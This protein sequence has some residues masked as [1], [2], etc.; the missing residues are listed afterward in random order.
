MKNIPLP[1]TRR[2]FEAARDENGVPHVQAATWLDALFGL[3]YM[4][5][6][7]R[8]TQL[9][10]SR[11][12]ASGRGAEEISDT[13]EL[14]ETDRFFRRIGLNLDLETEIRILDDRT[15]TQLTAYCEGVNDGL[16]GAGRSLPM[17]AAGFQPQPWNQQSVLLIG[18][19][20]SF[21]GLAV[22]QMQN[23]RLLIELIHA[24]VDDEALRDLFA[25][26]L[27][28]VDFAMIRQIKMANQL[29]DEA[30]ELITDLPRL[31]GSNAWAVSP[32]R[33]ATGY[34]LL[35]ADPHLEINRLPAIWY[36]AVLE[37]GNQY[38]MGASLPGCPMFAVARTDRLAW[39][40]TYMKGDTVDY[41]VEDCRPGG[42]T[43]WQY[44]R[45]ESWHDFALREEQLV[46]K[47]ADDATLKVYESPQGIVDGDLDENGEGLH[48]AIAWS[49]MHEGNGTAI[50]AWLDV[51]AAKNARAAMRVAR[52]CAQPTLCWVFADQEGHI[53]LQ[54]CGRFPKRGGGQIGLAPIPA[55]DEAN[56]WQGWIAS[57]L[58]PNVYDPPEGF[59]A[60]ANEEK[61]LAGMPMLVTQ[62]LNDYRKRR[63]CERLAEL[64]AATMDDMQSLQYDLISL[65]ARD[66]LALFLPHLPDGRVKESLSSWDY[67][68]A[69]NGNEATLFLKLYRNVIV[70]LLGH[71]QGIGWR[72][73]LYICT[74]AGYSM[75]VL[76]A[77]DRMLKRD[78][79]IWWR[80]RDKGEL[81]RRAGER[82]E[83]EPDQPWSSVNN[84]HFTD[85][86]FGKHQVGRMLG[87]NSRR[88]PMPGNHATPFQG[89]VLQTATRE[90]TFAPS[91]HFVTDLGTNEAWTN[92]P[93]GPSESRFS[94]Y[95]KNDV[96]RWF[97]GEYKNLRASSAL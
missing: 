20:L 24:G 27:D 36:E 68:Y 44:R 26:R 54:S 46:R 29:S 86:F 28:N 30:L 52:E 25:P 92:L 96:A 84:F 31:A 38:V 89:H 95:Y 39:G 67:S 76:A 3:G 8:P 83:N 9:L 64:P 69:P 33:S 63:I 94:K 87:F 43:G 51:I 47:G 40:V 97:A 79:S 62:P 50:S 32:Q 73:M 75:M 18:K 21:G 57:E 37:W 72:R 80:G 5:A 41:F 16:E 93:G 11:S 82:T 77:A 65:Q 53:G 71:E 60:T 61:N 45:D 35:A 74:R 66:L 55:W 15:F 2:R 22:S 48:L 70:E 42:E 78:D 49:G 34:A 4:H 1:K 17:W 56:H 19:L 12:V 13:P 88:Y 91:Y 90:S 6:T 10:F 7:D 14:L 81:I 23:E 59:L 58:L 85:R